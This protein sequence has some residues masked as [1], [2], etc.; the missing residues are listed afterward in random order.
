MSIPRTE[1]RIAAA[2]RELRMQAR[3]YAAARDGA[4]TEEDTRYYSGAMSGILRGRQALYSVLSQ[5]AR[6]RVLGEKRGGA[7]A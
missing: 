3:A 2:D 6:A 1:A 4:K 5:E 7:P